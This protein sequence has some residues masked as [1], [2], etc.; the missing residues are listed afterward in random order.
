[1]KRWLL[2]AVCGLALGLAQAQTLRWSSQ[3]DPQTMDPHSQN[4]LMTN[5]A[6][7]QVYERLVSRDKQL[8]IVPG[9]AAEWTQLS[10]LLWRFKLRQ[11]VKFH[12]GSPFTAD[13]VVFSLQRARDA[14]SQVAVY[15]NALGTPRKIDDYTVELQLSA[16]NPIVLQ[17]LDLM[18]MMSKRW[19][20]QH[21]A[22]RPL[23]FKNREEGYTSLHANGTGPYKLVSRQPGIKTVYERNPHWWGS[24]EGNVQEVVYTP[25][26]N[27]ATRLAALVSGEIDLVLD[28]APRDVPRLRN[29]PGVRVYEGPE[30]RIIFIGMDQMRDKLLHAKV[31]GDKNPF[32]DIRVRR[33]MYQ[34]IDIEAIRQKLMNGMSMP[35]GGLT[36]SPLGAYSD[37]ALEARLPLDVAGARKLMAEAGYADGFEV[38]LDCPNNRYINDESICLALASMWSQLKIKVRVNAMPRVLY[39]PKLEKYDTS[40]FMLGWGGAITDAETTMTAVLRNRGDKGIG[41]YN[42]GLVINDRFDQLAAQSSVE[43][44]PKKREQL[45]KTAL[46][47]YREQVHLIPLHRQMIPWAARE[48]VTPT[49]RADN[50]LE[51]AWVQIKR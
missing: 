8:R 24:F 50:W 29:T 32:K 15:A 39:F 4:E 38:T 40:L 46:A 19:C 51:F 20:E 12:D 6:N 44:D 31:P 43:P 10:P 2:L 47:E 35:T 22:L 41:S 49:H 5:M 28:P 21:R 23:D 27:D 25:I 36:S 33:A 26:T 13:D 18:W 14:N 7:G 45:I 42:Y 17:H 30:N 9:L 1:M 37:A 16:F 34:A 11:G 48:T 3:G